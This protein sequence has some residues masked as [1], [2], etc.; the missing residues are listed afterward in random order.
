MTPSRFHP[1]AESEMIS[2]AM[3]YESQ[4]KDLGKRFLSTVQDSI[5]HIQ[6]NPM[7]YPIVHLD[8]RRCMTRTFPFGVIFRINPGSIVIMAVMHLH[9]HPD[10]WKSRDSN[11]I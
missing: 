4:Q 1:E 10:Y 7:I 9:R 5:S 11:Q 8:A 6:I 3:Y 2:A